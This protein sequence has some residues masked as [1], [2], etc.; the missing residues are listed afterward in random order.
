M[1]T[2][3]TEFKD[4]DLVPTSTSFEGLRYERRPV[5]VWV[6]GRWHATFR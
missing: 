2:T 4:H 3:A 6:S 1:T 5:R